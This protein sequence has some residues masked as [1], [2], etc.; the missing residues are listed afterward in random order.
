MK[1]KII[2]AAAV[3][4]ATACNNGQAELHQLIDTTFDRAAEQS[5]LLTQ[6]ALSKGDLLPRTFE[7]GKLKTAGYRSWIS[8]FFPGTL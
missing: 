5:L 1:F 8:G 7:D 6:D 2:Y 3:V 4:A